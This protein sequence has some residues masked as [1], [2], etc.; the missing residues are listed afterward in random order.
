MRTSEIMVFFH[1]Y[2]VI[3]F[4][5][6][7]V[8]SYG[9]HRKESD[10]ILLQ[11]VCCVLHLYYCAVLM[12]ILSVTDLRHLAFDILCISCMAI[13]IRHNSEHIIF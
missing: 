11:E 4:F 7:I 8:E 6:N 3:M 5:V 9:R 2:F 13:D 1:F 12:Q 10:G